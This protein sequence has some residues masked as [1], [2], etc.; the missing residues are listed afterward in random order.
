[1]EQD[2]E[3]PIPGSPAML[4]HVIKVRCAQQ[5]QL[6]WEGLAVRYDSSA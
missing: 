1:M 6:P 5:A 4:K 3:K 2:R